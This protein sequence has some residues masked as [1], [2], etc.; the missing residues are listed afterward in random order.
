MSHQLN[1]HPRPLDAVIRDLEAAIEAWDRPKKQSQR[2]SRYEVRS[3]KSTLQDLSV[4]V[5]FEYY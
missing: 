2:E 1:V 5:H 3:L 4:E